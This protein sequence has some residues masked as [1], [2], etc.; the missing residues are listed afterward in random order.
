MTHYPQL[1][2]T[3]I[4][5][6]IQALEARGVRVFPVAMNAPAPGDVAGAHERAERDRTFYLKAQGGRR[7]LPALSR[8]VLASPA[9]VAVTLWRAVRTAGADLAAMLWRVFHVV[10]ALLVWDHCR[11]NG[12]R[13]IHAHFGLTPAT[14]AWFASAFGN[15]AGGGWTWSFT[16]H[17]FQDFV[18]EREAALAA[19][20]AS[21][22]HVVCVSDFTRSQLMR[23]TPP[24]QWGKFHV[25]RCGIDLARFAF[26]PRARLAAVPTVVVV[27]RLSPEKGGGV[28]LEAL[29][30][31]RADGVAA[32][33]EF[34][35]DGEARPALEAQAARLG[36]ADRVRFLGALHPSEVPARLR[37]ADV[38]CLPS[39]AE[40]LPVSIMEAMAVG[41]PVV[42]T[43]ISG[44]PELA[45]DGETAL[46]VPA[47]NA[48]RLA[49][50]L[51]RLL[52]NDDLRLRLVHAARRR[53]EADHAL[54]RNARMLDE[55]L[56]SAVRP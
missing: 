45:V 39:F 27:G 8:A 31:L 35:G 15:R 18:N 6:E 46:V 47:G 16:I 52:G 4:A 2:V 3:F 11:R 40:G 7:V 55:L 26:E 38:F 34:V 13:H 12:V 49:D 29:G 48:R 43:Y 25:V 22:S 23:I 56:A 37:Q 42:T 54:P 36:I 9:G 32:V 30:G 41:T 14:I 24:E 33:V 28:L 17:G 21:A 53:V 19:K 1:F 5:D 50:A 44:I 20:A 10:E 51:A